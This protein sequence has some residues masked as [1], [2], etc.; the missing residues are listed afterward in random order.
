MEKFKWWKNDFPEIKIKKAKS[1]LHP[2]KSSDSIEGMAINP[3]SGCQ[4]RCIY[5]YATYEWFEDFYDSV[6]VKINSPSILKREL[7]LYGTS[8]PVMLGS[9]TDV[10]QPVELKFRLTK[11]IIEILQSYGVEY[12]IFT[13][14]T[15]VLLDKEL[16]AR[17]SSK[18]FIIW[19]L[20]T[21]DDELKRKIEPY[22]AFSKKI[23]EAI[24]IM[25]SLNIKCGLNIDPIL[26]G[27]TDSKKMISEMI[28][29]A[30]E[31][32]CNFISAGILR[33]RIDIWKRYREFLMKEYEHLIPYYNDLYFKRP[34][35][36]CGYYLVDAKYEEEMLN[37][38]EEL[39]REKGVNFGL[40]IEV[41]GIDSS[42]YIKPI[43]QKSL[44]E[45]A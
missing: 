24:K 40:P 5:C 18:C 8:K 30:K 3:Y 10:Y 11:K 33:L 25:R 45:Y 7:P 26:P 31:S 2:F 37:F 13:K 42:C 4:H 36:H 20:T 28:N 1:L 35:L 29:L 19:S 17:Y 41:P 12:Y 6:Y 27:L 38:I 15:S 14:S 16:H 21:I 9:A 43:K 34:R 22:A 23:F 39:C 32:N 44:L